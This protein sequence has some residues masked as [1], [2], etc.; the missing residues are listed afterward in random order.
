MKRLNIN[1]Y[2]YI[3]VYKKKHQLYQMITVN[4]KI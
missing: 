1:E 3:Y 4:F 2:A